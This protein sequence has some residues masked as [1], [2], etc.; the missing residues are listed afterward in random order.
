[1]YSSVLAASLFGYLFAF[2]VGL[3]MI[4]AAISFSQGAG[5]NIP[6]QNAFETSLACGKTHLLRD[7]SIW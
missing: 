6:G 7:V 1:M 2:K 5:A 3:G 4:L